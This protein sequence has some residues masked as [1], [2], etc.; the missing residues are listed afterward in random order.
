MI[1]IGKMDTSY[2]YQNQYMF[3]IQ[4]SLNGKKNIY[5]EVV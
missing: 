5:L 1:I 4:L 3:K 2:I